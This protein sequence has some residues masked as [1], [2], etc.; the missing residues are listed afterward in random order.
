MIIDTS[1]LIAILKGEPERQRFSVEIAENHAAISAGTLAEAFIVAGRLAGEAGVREIEAMLRDADVAV[2]PVDLSQAR[3]MGTA[4]LAYGRGSGHPAKL[5]YGDCF[6]YALAIARDEPL[7]F[8]GDD[9]T[10]TDVR[11]AG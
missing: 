8:K 5:N 11:R 1:A 10:H 6:S 7:L 9:F 4:H 2:V 3:L